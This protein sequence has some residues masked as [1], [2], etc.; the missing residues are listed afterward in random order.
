MTLKQLVLSSLAFISIGG[1]I[2]SD[3]GPARYAAAFIRQG[4]EP[5]I[6]FSSGLTVTD[7]V[8]RHGRWINRYWLST[9]LIKPEYHLEQE[10]SVMD[11]LPTDAFELSIEGE[12]LARSWRW[13]KAEQSKVQNPQGHLVTVELASTTRP[14]TVKICTLLRGGPVMVRWL[15]ITNTGKKSTAITRVSPWS[16]MLW[17]APDYAER[18]D[19]ESDVVFEAASCQYED[20]GHEGG[21]KF[22]PILNGSKI[23]SGTRGKSGWGHPTFFARNRATG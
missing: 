12:D 7:E 16:G 11:S 4:A 8:L 9:G 14:I 22:E 5:G 3:A 17:N 23:V 13:V 15:E 10:I 20:W 18:I 2:L 21:W 19:K 1:F 6:R